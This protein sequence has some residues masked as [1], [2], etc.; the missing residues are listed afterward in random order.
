MMSDALR[1]LTPYFIVML[2][3]AIIGCGPLSRLGEKLR[4]LDQREV[5]TKKESA[6][7]IAGFVGAGLLL[8][9]CMLRLT[10]SSY[11]PFIYFRF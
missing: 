3:A 6:W 7:H 10:G 4:A 5:L 2:A 11:N 1:Q 8:L 9:W